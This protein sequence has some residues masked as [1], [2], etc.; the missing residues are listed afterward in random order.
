MHDTWMAATA[1]L[2]ETLAGTTL[3]HLAERD[4]QLLVGDYRT[5]ADSHRTRRPRTA[6]SR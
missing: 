3:A 6:E 4:V 1:A 5:P 2:R